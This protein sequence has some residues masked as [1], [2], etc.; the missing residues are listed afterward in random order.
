MHFRGRIDCIIIWNHGLNKLEDILLEIRENKFEILMIEK[1]SPKSI[2]NLISKVYEL[3]D[4]PLHHLRE[5]TRFLKNG[6][7]EVCF[8]FIKNNDP[9]EDFFGTQP[10]RHIES[11]SLKKLKTKIRNNYNPYFKGNRTENH[12][13]H[14]TDTELQTRNIFKYLTGSPD[15]NILI[16]THILKLPYYLASYSKFKIFNLDL[17]LDLI[18]CKIFVKKEK[19]KIV[20]IE[21]TPHFAFLHGDVET[22]QEYISKNLGYGLKEDYTIDRYEKLTRI[23]NC[24]DNTNKRYPIAVRKQHGYFLILDGLHRTCISSF[25][26]QKNVLACEIIE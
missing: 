11:K 16:N 21:N 6:G 2:K 9:E 17:D 3:D 1:H 10:F 26:G 18:R 25:H 4:V 8:V 23:L 7:K 20:K 12:V 22:Y 24:R 15:I 13:I 19:T 14:C 5:K